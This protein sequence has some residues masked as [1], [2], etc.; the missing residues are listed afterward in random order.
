[1][2]HNKPPYPLTRLPENLLRGEL[3][4]ATSSLFSW[5]LL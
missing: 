3:E 1:M 2:T 5:L 4:G